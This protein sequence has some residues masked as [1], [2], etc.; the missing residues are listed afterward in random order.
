MER[1]AVAKAE[2]DGHLKRMATKRRKGCDGA[3]SAGGGVREG[4]AEEVGSHPGG[5]SG[6]GDASG[7]DASQ[8]AA[9]VSRVREHA[10][11]VAE[12]VQQQQ[13]ATPE[14]SGPGE[15]HRG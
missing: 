8:P 10:A 5:A 7:S 1:A 6:S 3:A 9:S 13:Q 4:G 15:R 2:H 11:R 14:S 12:R